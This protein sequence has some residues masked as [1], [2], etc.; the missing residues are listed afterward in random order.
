TAIH[1]VRAQFPNAPPLRVNQISAK[2]GGWL[3]PHKSHQNGRDVDLAFYYPSAEPVRARE[4]EKYIDVA[5]TWALLKALVTHGR[6]QKVLYDYALKSGEDKAWLD[7]LFNGPTPL[8]QHARRHRDHM[9]VRLFSPRA[10]EL[11]R[12][13]APL[14]ALRPEQNVRM[15]RVKRGDT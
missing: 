13:V 5:K 14:L 15:H 10:Q 1:E 2:D 4:R 12:R 6:V 9:H 7:S 8:V 11:G 3:R